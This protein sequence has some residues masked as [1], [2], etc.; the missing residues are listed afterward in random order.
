MALEEINF[1]WHAQTRTQLPDGFYH[2]ILRSNGGLDIFLSDADRYWFL[3]LF[4]EGIGRDLPLRLPGSR[5][6]PHDQPF[7]MWDST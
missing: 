3:L 6:L 2:I 5:I 7:F 1:S 4:Q